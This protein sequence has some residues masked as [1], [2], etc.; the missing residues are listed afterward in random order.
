MCV[1]FTSLIGSATA[2]KLLEKGARKGCAK[3]GVSECNGGA[4]DDRRKD[5]GLAMC[6]LSL[7]PPLSSLLLLLNVIVEFGCFRTCIPL[8]NEIRE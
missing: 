5:T 8:G 1:I 3:E 2:T 4:G 6:V 7:P